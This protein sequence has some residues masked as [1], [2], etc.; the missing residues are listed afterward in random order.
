[1][2]LLEFDDLA[3]EEARKAYR[4]YRRIDADLAGR[5]QAAFDQAVIEIEINPGTAPKHLRGTRACKVKRFPY[6]IVFKI[7]SSGA[8]VAYAVSHTSRKPGYWWKRT[9]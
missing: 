7:K 3:T 9:R 5:F 6:L 4:W 1:M 2:P 8:L